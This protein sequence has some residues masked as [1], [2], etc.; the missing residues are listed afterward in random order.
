MLSSLPRSRPGDVDDDGRAEI[1]PTP[2]SACLIKRKGGLSVDEQK[3]VLPPIAMR[4]FDRTEPLVVQQGTSHTPVKRRRTPTTRFALTKLPG[5]P[6]RKEG[7][8]GAGPSE[9]ARGGNTLSVWVG[10]NYAACR[11]R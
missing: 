1:Q 8:V 5:I 7:P 3:E 2:F 6:K 11:S 4:C 10:A 9:I